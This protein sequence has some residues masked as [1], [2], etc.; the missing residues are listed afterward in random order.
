MKNV[1]HIAMSLV[2]AVALTACS[3]AR[4]KSNVWDAYDIRHPVPAESQVPISQATQYQ[5]YIDNDAYYTL[6]DGIYPADPD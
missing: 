1:I 5:Q 3:T 2:V 6:P 4:P